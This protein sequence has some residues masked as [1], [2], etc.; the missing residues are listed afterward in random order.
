MHLA[1]EYNLPRFI[2]KALEYAVDVIDAVNS[3]PKLTGVTPLHRAARANSASSIRFLVSRGASINSKT[4]DFGM[5]PLHLAGA[6]GC[7]SAWQALLQDVADAP[8][9]LA[10]LNEADLLGRSPL[11]LSKRSGWI[12]DSKDVTIIAQEQRTCSEQTCKTFIVTNPLCT[13]HH[14]CPP[15]QVETAAAPPENI[16][17]LHVLV[18]EQKGALCS[19][20]LHEHLSW[21]RSS[22]PAAL[23]DVLRVHE[24]SYVRRVQERCATIT[25]ADPEDEEEGFAH[26][27]G[28]TAISCK[29]YK[30][31]LAAAGAVCQ[32][33]KLVA[34]SGSQRAARN[35][36]CPVRPPGH[37]AGP[38]GVVKGHEP[39]ASDSHG[40]CILNNVSIGAAYAM[41]QYRDTVKKVAIV[42]FGMRL[43]LHFILPTRR[44]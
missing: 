35:A 10:V 16:K 6:W 42:D 25:S 37:H 12:P 28:D 9:Q 31:A 14:T 8:Q 5:T 11:D 33:V 1:A 17:R 18:D 34:G 41:N 7:A 39:G 27:D 2:V 21:V 43:L 3:A 36:F 26:L 32:A 38:K 13:Q 44:V 4:T 15:S 22:E 40:F 30:A 19:V 23:A 29:T 20:D 24:W